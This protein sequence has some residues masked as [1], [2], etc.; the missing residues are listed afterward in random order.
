MKERSSRSALTIYGI[1]LAVVSAIVGLLWW[2]KMPSTRQVTEIEYIQPPV[3]AQPPE[4]AVQGGTTGSPVVGTV[5]TVTPANSF[6]PLGP[7][8]PGGPGGPAGPI[9]PAGPS[10]NMP[11]E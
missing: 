2:Q 1:A 11:P 5:T 9:G 10:G 3:E 6:G 4:P 7:F 8:G